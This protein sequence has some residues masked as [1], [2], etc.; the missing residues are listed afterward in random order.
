MSPDS[1]QGLHGY[2]YHCLHRTNIF[3]LLLF[4]HPIAAYC[5]EICFV[6]AM[7]HFDKDDIDLYL[8]AA[9]DGRPDI[10]CP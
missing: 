3:C 2:V 4:M 10:N 7:R 8:D 5:S 9:V 6:G 1:L